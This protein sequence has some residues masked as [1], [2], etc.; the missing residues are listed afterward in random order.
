MEGVEPAG[1]EAA[2]EEAAGGTEGVVVTATHVDSGETAT[3][4]T[5]SYGDFWLKDLK[6]GWYTLRIEKD[7]YLPQKFGPVD[8]TEKDAN[9]GDVAMWKA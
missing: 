1:E 9:I 5:D 8:V 4:K 7:G 6:D 2:G 3:A